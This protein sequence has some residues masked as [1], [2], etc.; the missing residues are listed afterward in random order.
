MKKT[1]LLLASV[2]VASAIQLN[3]KNKIIISKADYTLTVINEDG[4]PIFS[5]LCSVGRNYGNKER[6]GDKK[7]PEGTFYIKSIENALKWRHNIHNGRGHV[8][9]VYGPWFLRLGGVPNCNSIGIHGTC[10][11][12][13]MGTHTSLG[14][15]RLQNEEVEKLVDLVETGTVVEI[16]PEG[17]SYDNALPYML[18]QLGSPV[19]WHQRYLE[20]YE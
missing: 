9:G 8:T 12:A 4:E 13:T 2:I 19:N 1:L 5:T 11:N 20:A 3:A 15:I 18:P 6:Q 17:E 10:F 7:T 16:L 14:C